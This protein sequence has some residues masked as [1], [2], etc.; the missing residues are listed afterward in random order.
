MKSLFLYVGGVYCA[1]CIHKIEGLFRGDAR[2]R[3]ARLNLSAKRFSIVWDGDADFADDVFS[4]IAG[5]GYDVKPYDVE[6]AQ[7]ESVV[8]E[9]FLLL[10]LGIAG[11]AMGNIMLLSVGVWSSSAEV[12]GEA[13][14][15]LM[16]WISAGI[17]LPTIVFAGRPFFR[18]AISALK[19]GHSNMDV[20]ISLALVL[21]SGMS[22]FETLNHGEHVYFDSAVMLM[23][24]LLIGR[25][26]D[27]YARKH[28]RSAASELLQSVGSFANVLVEGKLQRMAVADVPVGAQIVVAAGERFPMDGAVVQGRSRVDVSLMNG[29]SLPQD[30]EVGADVYSGTLNLEAPLVFEVRARAE[31]S[32]L[33]EIVRLMEVAEQGQAHYVRMADRAARLY[34]PFV[35]S[36]A[37]LTFVGWMVIGGLAWQPALMI[38]ITVLIITCPCALGLAV[39]VVQVLASGLLMRA[40]VFIK[41]GDALERLAAVDTIIFDKTGTLT[42]GDLSLVGAYEVEDLRLAASLAVQSAHPLSKAIAAVY[43][44]ELLPVSDVRE[45]AGQGIEGVYE[46]RKIRLGSRAWCGDDARAAGDD[47]ELWLDDGG[48]KVCFHF[49]DVLRD[50]AADVIGYFQAA[51]MEVLL[52]SGDRAVIADSVA[53]EIGIARVFA[54]ATPQE[55]YDILSELKVQGHK[56]LMVGDG[57]ND[58]P[59]LA[60][61]YVSVAPGSG[62]DVSQKAADIVFMGDQL[63]PLWR[64]YKIA[65]RSQ[66]LVKQNFAL[67]VLYNI[68]AVPLAVAG[69]VTP[70]IAALC[71][72]GSSLVVILNS[73]RLRVMGR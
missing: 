64:V 54:E 14:R 66:S 51:G 2:V 10:C 6:E 56:V 31:D 59:A 24:F 33:A 5:L 62:I 41:S 18:S 25:Y 45:L 68:I 63:A 39:P 1:A 4:R 48:C 44:G 21:A 40:G 7:S 11:F 43:G 69:F 38:A 9:K 26:L 36:F 16:H 34:T 52:V 35:H 65:R 8:E 12:M 72:S 53:A 3:S 46:G 70:F 29:E 30:V 28:A 13:M 17:A 22:L 49:R 60:G 73:F 58:A 37:A 32:F 61:A 50:D 19:N 27:F 57:L 20:P 71:M 47:I 67:A 42:K 23:F 15:G 55:K